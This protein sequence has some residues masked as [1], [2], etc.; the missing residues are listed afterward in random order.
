ME[1][2]TVKY[3]EDNLISDKAVNVKYFSIYLVI[4]IKDIE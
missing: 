1:T 2:L 4:N 3:T